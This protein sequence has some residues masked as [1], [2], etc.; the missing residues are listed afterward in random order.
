MSLIEFNFA[1][2]TENFI[3]EEYS[4]SASRIATLYEYAISM[5]CTLLE[6]FQLEAQL[7]PFFVIVKMEKNLK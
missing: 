4:E 5:T 3:E 1:C 6:K 7:L 2:L